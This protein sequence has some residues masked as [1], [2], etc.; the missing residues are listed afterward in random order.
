MVMMRLSMHSHGLDNVAHV[1]EDNEWPRSTGLREN[2]K[3]NMD[4][5]LAIV[6]GSRPC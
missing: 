1:E 3:K 4:V 6:M 2:T 5:L